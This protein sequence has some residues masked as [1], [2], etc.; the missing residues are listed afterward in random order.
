M[1]FIV[2]SLQRD[3]DM[4]VGK[5]TKKALELQN[6]DINLPDTVEVSTDNIIIS[7]QS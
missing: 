4:L 3:N 2:S 6:E 7:Y 1:L 5:Y